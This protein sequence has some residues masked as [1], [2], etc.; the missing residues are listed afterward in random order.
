MLPTSPQSRRVVWEDGMHLTPQHF[1]AQRRYHEEQTSRTIGLLVPFAYGLSAIALD[2]DGLRNGT[3]SLI[4]ARG[5]LPDGTVFHLSDAD[6]I[7]APIHLQDRFS[8]MRDS[9]VVHLG[10]PQW[11]ADAA[12]L[13]ESG[14]STTARFRS[15]EEVITDESTGAD[16]LP[17]RFAAHNLML[18]LDD[19]L[20][21]ELVTLPI[22]MVRRDAHGQFQFDH[23]F[24][25]PCLQ[26]GAS[27]RLTGLI[28]D[29]TDLLEAKGRSLAATLASAP[30]GAVG[31]SAAYSG[32]ELA[33]RWLLHAV[34]SS[35]ALLRHL[36]QARQTHPE[37][38]YI[39]LSRLAGA[40]TT[41]SMTASQQ[42]VPLYDHDELTATFDAL[43]RLLRNHLSVVIS[44][45]TLVIPLQHSSELLHTGAITDH[46]CFEPGARWFLGVSGNL[47]HAELIDRVQRLSKTCSSKFVLELVRRAFNGLAIEHIPVPPSG[48]AP[49]PEL[50]YFELT[51]SGP[52]AVSLQESREIGVYVPEA[53]PGVYI[54]LA[55]LLPS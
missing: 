54:E 13:S 11:T 15:R 34:R 47:G 12:N 10:L 43:E 24:V 22:A 26:S 32:N 25:P 50:T 3:L 19:E 51:M 28:R 36:L 5:V 2:E 53:L 52:C 17:V 39:E 4:S 9:H 38:L 14:Q 27:P 49:R 31:G 45:R 18:L 41:F 1:Q 30:A 37:H 40:L 42:D 48:L 20:A 35:E 8:P 44:A 55:V 16:P 23:G 7:P 46:R 33:T 21:A 29:L 6:E